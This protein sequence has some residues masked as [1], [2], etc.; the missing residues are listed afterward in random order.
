MHD[1]AQDSFVIFERKLDFKYPGQF[2]SDFARMA[3]SISVVNNK[4][5]SSKRAQNLGSVSPNIS[6][7]GFLRKNIFINSGRR[8]GVRK[9]EFASKLMFLYNNDTIIYS[10]ITKG[11]PILDHFGG[12]FS[13]TTWNSNI[14]LKSRAKN[15]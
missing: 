2:S 5:I 1:F 7:H 14:S 13:N 9:I 4:Y 15:Y 12:S 6:L 11:M 8:Y 3:F 10:I